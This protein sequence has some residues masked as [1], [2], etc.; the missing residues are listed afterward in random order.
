MIILPIL[1]DEQGTSSSYVINHG[2]RYN[3]ETY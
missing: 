2:L 1:A 3:D